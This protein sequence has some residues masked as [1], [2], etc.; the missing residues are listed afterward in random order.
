[1][2]SGRELQSLAANQ[3]DA[4]ILKHFAY[5]FIEADLPNQAVDFYRRVL[6]LWPAYPE[7]YFDMGLTM[8]ML[9]RQVEAIENYRQAI[10][11]RPDYFDA[12]LNLG[13]V[14]FGEGEVDEA[15]EHFN[16]AVSLQP[17]SQIAIDNLN[18]AV[19]QRAQQS[20]TFDP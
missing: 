4:A 2:L 5:M 8:T 7:V 12:R 17:D 10:Q 15:I 16:K 14:L 18:Y 6:Q 20:V 1:L 3:E 13:A 11:L 19:E 9:G